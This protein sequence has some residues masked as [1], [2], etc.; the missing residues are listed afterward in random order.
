MGKRPATL[1]TVATLRAG[2]AA[3][4]KAKPYGATRSRH[5]QACWV[6]EMFLNEWESLA[7]E[8]QWATGDIFDLPQANRSGL[9]YW[10]GTDI[11]TALGP[12]HAVTETNRVF[13]RIAKFT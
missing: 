13:D 11:V 10:L 12:E 4:K 8:F 7:I 1:A 3:F 6:A 2:L 5:E 9:A